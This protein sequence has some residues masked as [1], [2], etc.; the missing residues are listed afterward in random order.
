MSFFRTINGKISLIFLVMSLFSIT[1]IFL[2]NN[3]AKN[4]Y[5]MRV[6]DNEQKNVE[7]YVKTMD[8][9]LELLENMLMRMSLSNYGLSELEK[10]ENGQSIETGEYWQAV[11]DVVDYINSVSSVYGYVE[12]VF[13]YYPGQDLFIHS[14]V[15][16]QMTE[17]I[18]RNIHENGK[19]NSDGWELVELPS[20][21]YLYR[22]FYLKKAY[23]GAWFSCD[24]LFHYFSVAMQLDD[25][26]MSVQSFLTD[27]EGMILTVGSGVAKIDPK[28]FLKT[29]G[30]MKE[31][32]YVSGYLQIPKLFFVRRIRLDVPWISGEW[33]SGMGYLP[34]IM[35]I[36]ILTLVV[37]IG[38]LMHW[39]HRPVKHLISAIERISGGDLEYRLPGEPGMS[40]EFEQ[41]CGKF[42]E[43][44]EQIN[45]TKI[46]I[47]EQELEKNKIRLRHLSQQI[48]PHFM[49][50]A[51]NTLYNYSRRDIEITRKI[52][53]LLSTY[54]RYVVNVDSEYVPLSE[55]LKHIENYLTFQKLRYED[56]LDYQI[57]CES[58]LKVIPVPPFLIE[59]FIGNS[60]K[61]GAD[62]EDY[63]RITVDV[64]QTD[65]FDLSIRIADY[66]SGFPEEVI[67]AVR[68]YK[69]TGIL[70]EGLGI[71]I[72]NSMERLRLLYGEKATL[73]LYNDGGAVTDIR[74]YLQ[75]SD[76]MG[77]CDGTDGGE[78][79]TDTG[80][81]Y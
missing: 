73:D 44:L 19:K 18:K 9:S 35:G 16:E 45:R 63:I 1:G 40:I 48:R 57:D 30:G 66:G 21:W 64:R 23:V 8:T 25:Q 12:N 68:E 50:N 47:Y 49:L 61:Y 58:A 75:K 56:M 37:M 53:R 11:L 34:F 5:G 81:D 69:K 60:L 33:F 77:E 17:V 20:G 46:R 43:M 71:G 70:G 41:I 26:N 32:I 79:G 6:T 42:N 27:K 80:P 36:D 14:K 78:N 28:E 24:E 3:Y 4:N 15:N 31:E 13:V 52:I 72:C 2:M 76:G 54:Y 39:V 67:V 10:V 51:L 65:A 29:S 74:I 62:E 38:A 55:E 22:I 7:V 59:S